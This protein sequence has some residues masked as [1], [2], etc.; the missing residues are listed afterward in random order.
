LSSARAC[1]AVTADT[2]TNIPCLLLLLLQTELQ[3]V[4]NSHPQ[5]LESAE[6][7]QHIAQVAAADEA[8]Q[9]RKTAVGQLAYVL[10]VAQDLDAAKRALEGSGDPTVDMVGS[11]SSS[12]AGVEQGG[13]RLGAAAAAAA[14]APADLP[15]PED[16]AALLGI[17]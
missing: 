8:L 14:A 2:H 15:S 11:S 1:P 7:K 13:G 12:S 6:A 4:R 16:L 5:L 17:E 10:D 9:R 3:Q